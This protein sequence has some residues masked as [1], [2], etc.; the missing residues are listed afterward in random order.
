MDET[1]VFADRIRLRATKM[2]ARQGFGYLGQAL[3]S[4]ELIA[5]LYTGPY[6]PTGDE[7]RQQTEKDRLARHVRRGSQDGGFALQEVLA[8]H[9]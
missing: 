8:H 4:A 2:I 9:E 5:S 7:A 6:R 1:A 3:S